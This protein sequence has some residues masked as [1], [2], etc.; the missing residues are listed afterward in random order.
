MCVCE[1]LT[2][3]VVNDNDYTRAREGGRRG[4]GGWGSAKTRIIKAFCFSF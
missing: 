2:F 4:G 3:N 1:K